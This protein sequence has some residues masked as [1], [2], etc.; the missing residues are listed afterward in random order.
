MPAHPFQF[1]YVQPVAEEKS[2]QN[3][4]P[5]ALTSDQGEAALFPRRTVPPLCGLVCSVPPAILQGAVV[6]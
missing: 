3:V 1:C 2:A 4:S 6:C 5:G